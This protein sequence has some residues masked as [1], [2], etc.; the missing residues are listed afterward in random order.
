VIV[1]NLKISEKVDLVVQVSQF[2]DKVQVKQGNPVFSTALSVFLMVGW[3]G[4]EGILT[5][6]NEQIFAQKL[7]VEPVISFHNWVFFIGT[8]PSVECH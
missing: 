7:F 1:W 4:L 5:R 6:L 3:L 2:I 8:L